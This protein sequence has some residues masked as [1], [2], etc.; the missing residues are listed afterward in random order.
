MDIGMLWY[1]DDR[2]RPL[3]EKV[4]RAVEHYRAKYGAVPTVCYVN[5][6]TL[7]DGAESAAGVQLLKARNVLVDHF[8]IGVGDAPGANGNGK[9]APKNGHARGARAGKNGRRAAAR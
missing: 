1:D 6:V 3:G 8:W 2:K 5:P 4:A 9:H 7:R